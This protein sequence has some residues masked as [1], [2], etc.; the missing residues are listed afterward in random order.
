MTVLLLTGVQGTV[1]YAEEF[2]VLSGKLFIIMI[3]TKLRLRKP[4]NLLSHPRTLNLGFNDSSRNANFE[5]RL[6]G[7]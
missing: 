5:C 3:T 2:V 4:V 7:Y 6:L 1:R